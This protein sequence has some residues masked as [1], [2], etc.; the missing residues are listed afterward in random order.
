MAL[1]HLEG[2]PN[3]AALGACHAAD[4]HTGVVLDVLG[5]EHARLSSAV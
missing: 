3:H 2:A 5:N 1:K 4:E